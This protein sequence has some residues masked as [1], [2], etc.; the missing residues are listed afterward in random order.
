MDAVKNHFHSEVFPDPSLPQQIDEFIV[1]H[2]N[3]TASRL[4]D[5]LATEV[6]DDGWRSHSLFNTVYHCDC[7]VRVIAKLQAYDQLLLLAINEKLAWY[8]RCEALRCIEK[9]N[10]S[11]DWEVIFSIVEV[12]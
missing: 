7:S 10:P 8:I 11:I 5:V 2:P 3:D 9:A 4:F 1:K 12:E 6:E